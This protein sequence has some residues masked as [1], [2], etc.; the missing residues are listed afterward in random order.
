MWAHKTNIYKLCPYKYIMVYHE[1]RIKGNHS[2]NYIIHNAREDGK[3]KKK[4]KF[5]GNGRLSKKKIEEEIERFKLKMNKYISEENHKK[6]EEI[7]N[8]FNAYLSKGGKSLDENFR[9][10]FFTELTY[11]S[12]AIEGNTLSLKETSMIINENLVPK[13]AKLREVY[14]ARNYKEALEF[15]KNYKGELNEKLILKIHS[16]ILKDIDDSNAGR[17]RIVNVFISGEPNLKF[18][19]AGEI[20]KLIKELI[21]FYNK[22]KKK[23]H[24]LEL[25]TIISMKFVSIHPFVDGNGRV[26]RLLMNFIIKKYGYPEINIYFK[27]RQNYLRAVRKANDE[28][29]DLI[30]DFLIKTIIINYKFLYN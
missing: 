15:L 6:I 11:N 25:A 21:N 19:K 18:P 5:I 14:E 10:W 4:S 12:N 2:Y 1:V 24:P 7:K 29:Y 23:Y 9:E 16:L 20:S 26:S 27:D 3:W 30:I 8:K 17:Y 22:N 28:N 13:G